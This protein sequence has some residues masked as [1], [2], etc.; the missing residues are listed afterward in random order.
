MVSTFHGLETARR[1]MMTQQAALYVTGHNIANANTP[2]YTRQRVNFE[3]TQAYPPVGRNNAKIPGQIGTGVQAG[4]IQRIRDSFVDTQ[5]RG[6]NSKLG[7]WQAKAEMLTQ[8]EDIM[9]EPSDTGLAKSMDEFWNSL[10]DLAVQPQNNGARRVVRQRGIALAN[11]FNYMYNSLKAVQKDY[12]NEI[13][14]SET[15]IN[16]L[17]RQINQLNKQ[18]GSIEPH[19]YL[20]ND[21]YDERDRLVD[22]LSNLVNIKVEVKPSGGLA[23]ANAEGLYDIYLATPQGDKLKDSDGKEIQLV[24]T[25]DGKAYGIH[26]K[27]EDRTVL[28]SPVSEIRF[29][30]LKETEKGF[31]G[32]A[33][34][35]AADDD[36]A[37]PVYEL[38]KF[39]SFNT[40]GRLK[41]FIE[42]YGYKEGTDTK[43]L[44]NDMLSDLDKMAFTFAEQFNLVHQSGWS[45]NEI[46]DGVEH[47]YDFFDL[48]G[49]TADNPAGAAALIKVAQAIMDDV[50][51]IAAAAEGNVIAGSMER[52]SNVDN[53]T[54]GNPS[55]KG[56]Y[57]RTKTTPSFSDEAKE[58]K[59]EL[60]FDETSNS[61]SYKFTSYK[62]D[63]TNLDISEGTIGTSGKISLYGIDINTTLVKPKDDDSGIQTWSYTFLAE[64]VK[65]SDEAFI[66]NGSN[67]LELSKVKDALLN[68]GGS[69]TNVSTFYQ[70]MIGALGDQTSEALRMLN[71]S[72]T[73]KDSVEQRRMSI[74]NVSLD[75][76]M[77]NMIKFQHAY[78]AA[79]RQITLVDEMLDK[80]INGMGLVGR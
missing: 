64:G 29:F 28:D 41:G 5:F 79:A 20:P 24:N 36:N 51:N 78:N 32:L 60:S 67:A 35:A 27:Y 8:M 22:E 39:S 3:A 69:L 37:T 48:G 21:L 55:I 74:S 13:D 80:I 9:N 44:Y 11:T 23:S 31:V 46:R 6:E 19:G 4:D 57:D 42:G 14:I 52:T 71:T 25:T 26:I 18:I 56:I 49:L 62:S 66:G 38:S 73:L 54:V 53:K 12:R 40:N 33:D 50:D 16:S 75:E 1:G 65:S 30:E 68:Y 70:G 47:N 15:Q 2:G 61:W 76:E 17:L 10:Q 59:V 34:D 7:F 72:T 45:L 58:I 63:G 77:T 43:G